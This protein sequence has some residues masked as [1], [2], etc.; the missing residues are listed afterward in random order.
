MSEQR[1]ILTVALLWA[2]W[3]IPFVLSGV[4]HLANVPVSKAVFILPLGDFGA[5]LVI[6]WFWM[7]TQNV[8]L[9]SIA[10]G[11]LNNWGQYAFKFM[12]DQTPSAAMHAL[13]PF[14][15]IVLAGGCLSLVV[16]G[17]LLVG[18]AGFRPS[19]QAHSG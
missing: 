9:V 2:F 18:M 7:R 17:V 3:H 4:T 13:G 16:L 6:G 5:G 19:Q 14:E 15:S 12:Q 8:W 1:S 10:H 11:A